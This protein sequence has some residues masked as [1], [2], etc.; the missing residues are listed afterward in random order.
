MKKLLFTLSIIGMFILL[1]CNPCRIGNCTCI[2]W[3]FENGTG[4]IVTVKD[5]KNGSPSSIT[6]APYAF[7]EVYVESD[8]DFVSFDY[9]PRT[10][11]V[12]KVANSYTYKFYK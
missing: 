11:S 10:V 2:M 1:G 3:K 5:I 9:T 6:I 12:K 4:E 8:S 7:V